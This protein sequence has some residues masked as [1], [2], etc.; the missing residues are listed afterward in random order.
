MP[1]IPMAPTDPAPNPTSHY[2]S[3]PG[4]SPS[5]SESP[6]LQSRSDSE[7]EDSS[8]QSP[9][10]TSQSS[11]THSPASTLRGGSKPMGFIEFLHG[12]EQARETGPQ[13]RFLE[14]ART[15]LLWREWSADEAR[16]YLLGQ[17]G[18]LIVR[19]SSKPNCLLISFLDKKTG[20]ANLLV[21]ITDAG[22]RPAD[23]TVATEYA[24]LDALLVE[25]RRKLDR[26][27]GGPQ[28]ATVEK[29]LA[30][31][32]A[33]PLFRGVDAPQAIKLLTRAKKED[34]GEGPARNR[35][36]GLLLRP[37]SKLNSIAVSFCDPTGA[38]KHCSVQVL[39][40]GF[41]PEEKIGSTQIYPTIEALVSAI[42]RK[43]PG[44]VLPPLVAELMDA[45]RAHHLYRDIDSTNIGPMLQGAAADEVLIRQ[46][47]KPDC[48]S[49]CFFVDGKPASTLV[50]AH[51]TGAWRPVGDDSNQDFTSLD[52]MIETLQLKLRKATAVNAMLARA[53]AHPLFREVDSKKA[54]ELLA[55]KGSGEFV[56]RPSGKDP[57]AL[58]I[59][60]VSKLGFPQ[61][62][63]VTVTE[64]GYE[65]DTGLFANIDDLLRVA[66]GIGPGLLLF[67]S[68]GHANSQ[69]PNRPH[70][71]VLLRPLGQSQRNQCRP[72]LLRLLGLSRRSQ[73]PRA[74][75]PLSGHSQRNQWHPA[76]AL[77]LGQSQRKQCRP[78]LRRP[79]LS[80]PPSRSSPRPRPGA[81]AK[82][83]TAPRLPATPST[84]PLMPRPLQTSCRARLSAA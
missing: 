49:L 16:A 41:L 47:S 64:H 58:A 31:V 35:L 63:P 23:A 43:A 48:I 15:H 11:S 77:L 78:A 33:H 54:T 83:C 75:L 84:T 7:T 1:P 59:T 50:Q 61:H 14:Q 13:A 34:F 19:A 8:V 26:K 79:L 51:P 60:F 45:A 29:L 25:V 27:D 36:A 6:Q 53:K 76:L 66:R 57:R 32:V 38:V 17:P 39:P 12:Q 73:C 62:A 74:L 81:V 72:A 55:G 20:L 52:T 2:I 9:S 80:L 44:P 3:L 5:S 10:Q 82:I 56:L 40:S 22:Y 30:S 71:Q 70:L 42:P 24:T 37:S 65:T 21:H 4:V 68:R 67:F 46:S 69:C 28:Q 18:E